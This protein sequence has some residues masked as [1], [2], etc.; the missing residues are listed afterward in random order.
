MGLSWEL[1]LQAVVLAGAALVGKELLDAIGINLG[2]FG[3]IGGLVVALNFSPQM[4]QWAGGW[5]E[6]GLALWALG[7]LVVV[8]PGIRDLLR[9]D[10]E[11][12]QDMTVEVEHA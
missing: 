8:V 4:M 11:E 10:R 3:F 6:L 2:A 1:V 9:V 5:L 12:W 7:V